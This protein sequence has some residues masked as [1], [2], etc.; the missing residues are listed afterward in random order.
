V[1]FLTVDLIDGGRALV[2]CDQITSIRREQDGAEV[3]TADGD[4]MR[5]KTPFDEF[6]QYCR[7]LSG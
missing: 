3:R 7:Y 6:I 1:K 5:T 2:N 4:R